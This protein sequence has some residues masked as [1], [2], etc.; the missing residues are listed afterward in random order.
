MNQGYPNVDGGVATRPRRGSRATAQSRAEIIQMGLDPMVR[1]NDVEALTGLGVS[2]VYQM[3]HL[4]TFPKSIALTPNGRARGWRLSS[5]NTWL[6]ER[7]G[8]DR[9]RGGVK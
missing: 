6:A 2:M 4:G 3:Q 8:T 5:I 9:A 1:M 7:E